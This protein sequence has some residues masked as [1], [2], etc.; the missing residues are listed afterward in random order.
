MLII[1]LTVSVQANF[2]EVP[3]TWFMPNIFVDYFRSQLLQADGVGEGLAA[4]LH[5]EGDTNISLNIRFNL[6][7]I[8]ISAN[9]KMYPFIYS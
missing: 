2:I 8:S 5:R 7:F 9:F 3:A 1:I 4:G 6:I